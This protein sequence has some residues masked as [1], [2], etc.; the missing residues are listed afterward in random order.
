MSATKTTK[1]KGSTTLTPAATQTSPAALHHSSPSPQAQVDPQLMARAGADMFQN[2]LQ[3]MPGNWID[4]AQAK[5]DWQQQVD[6]GQLFSGSGSGLAPNLMAKY[7]GQMG[8]QMSLS[9]VRVHQGSHV[10][11]HLARA[12]LQGLTDGVNVAVSSQAQANTLEH[13]LGHVIQRQQDGF[14]LTEGSRS[15]YETHADQIAHQLVSGQPVQGLQAKPD[16]QAKCDACSAE[17]DKDLMAKPLPITRTPGPILAQRQLQA[18]IP[19][20]MRNIPGC[21]FTP[22]MLGTIG[23][24]LSAVVSCGLSGTLW[25]VAIGSAPTI[26]GPKLAGLGATLAGIK[27]LADG[28]KFLDKL[29]KY[30]QCIF[31]DPDQD[32]QTIQEAQDAEE[33]LRESQ[34]LMEQRLEQMDREIQNM[35]STNQAQQQEIEQLR[36]E[37]EDAKNAAQQVP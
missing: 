13:E 27:C 26:I 36:R 17:E 33:R 20:W 35:Q 32:A 7:E 1:P 16:L 37:L 29:I 8:G 22:A 4:R 18:F 24:G 2:V 6:P 23:S 34:R 21:T 5:T 10:D 25:A 11:T 30:I 31:R 14:Q 19:Q 12:G 28:F 9:H 3:S 15:H